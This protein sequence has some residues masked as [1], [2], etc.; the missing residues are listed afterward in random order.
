MDLGMCKYCKN[1]RFKEDKNGETNKQ[2][3]FLNLR[4]AVWRR[5][6]KLKNTASNFFLYKMVS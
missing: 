5:R 4:L 1:L 2:G 3:K 6:T